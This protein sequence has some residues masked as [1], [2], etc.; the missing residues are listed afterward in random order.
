[1]MK[2]WLDNP[3]EPVSDM[4]Y[5]ECLDT[6]IEK[7]KV[8][9]CILLGEVQPKKGSVFCWVKYSYDRAVCLSGKVMVGQCILSGKY[10]QRGQ[11]I[12]LGKVQLR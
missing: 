8:G 4:P 3:A 11:C 9:Q 10:S 7:S 2:S 1:M 12:L 5:F 6:V